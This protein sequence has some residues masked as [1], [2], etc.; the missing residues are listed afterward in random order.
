MLSQL[1]SE[2]KSSNFVRIY[3]IL[4]VLLCRS[5]LHNI[6]NNAGR[7]RVITVRT[8]R[9]TAETPPPHVLPTTVFIALVLTELLKK[10]YVNTTTAIWYCLCDLREPLRLRVEKLCDTFATLES[11]LIKLPL[12]LYFVFW[13]IYF[14]FISL[15]RYFFIPGIVI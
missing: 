15:F 6:N 9:V 4:M 11:L 8:G 2:A 3:F 7:Y 1:S 13:T 14:K 12:Y 5:Q 10:I